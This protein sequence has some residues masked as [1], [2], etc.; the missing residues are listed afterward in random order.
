MGKC[1][2]MHMPSTAGSLFLALLVCRTASLSPAPLLPYP[3]SQYPAGAL[4]PVYVVSIANLTSRSDII[5]LETLAGVLARTS[6]SIYVVT[7]D[8]SPTAHTAHSD[9]TVFW[10]RQLEITHSSVK[11]DMT[12]HIDADLPGLFIRFR[13]NVSGFV[14]YDPDT[15]S[16]NAAITHCAAASGGVV[17][18]GIGAK[19]EK[20]LESIGIPKLADLS[21]TSPYQE[22]ERSKSGLNNRIAIF[23]PD[24]GSKSQYLSAFAVFGRHPT[25]EHSSTDATAFNAVLSNFAQDA[26][27]AGLGWTSY[28]EHE[29]ISGL[30]QAGAYNHASD[31]LM[32]L[33]MLSNLPMNPQPKPTT[34]PSLTDAKEGTHT[35]A[36]MMSDGDNLQLLAGEWL[37]ERW[38]GSSQRGQVPLGWSYSP[39]TSVLMPAVLDWVRSTMTSN[40]S[41]QAGPSGAGY[42]YP[43]LFPNPQAELFAK[44]TSD[45]VMKSNMSVLNPIGVIPSVE[46]LVRLVRQDPVK[47]VVYFSFG[48]A[49]NG[50]SGLHGNVDYIYQKPIVGA[51]MNLWDEGDSGDKLGVEALVRELGT[52]PKQRTDP[53]SYSVVVVN[54]GSHNYSDVVRAVRLLE[55]AGGFDVVL[56]EVLIHRLVTHTYGNVT[57]PLPRGPWGLQAGDLPKCSIAGNG[58]CVMNCNNVVDGNPNPINAS[59]NLQTCHNLTLTQDRRHFICRDGSTCGV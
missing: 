12:T 18:V 13:S 22:F 41:L 21:Q 43:E 55:Q 26:L 58:S 44:A 38:Y 23:Q 35:V 34:L 25:V 59:C 2:P 28:D 36:F 42:A 17:A 31:Y 16:T 11:F 47:S 19:M 20:F 5:T 46:S 7:S 56:P 51:R 50:Y 39:A 40:D 24:D 3:R 30:T 33:E 37:S 9:T 52:L 29:F 1:K 54:M 8:P 15:N 27:N 57:C 14:T 48:K 4:G 45:L 6:P 10:L 53:N 32:N 49:E